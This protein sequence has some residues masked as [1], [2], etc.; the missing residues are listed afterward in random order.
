MFLNPK[1]GDHFVIILF[2]LYISIRKLGDAAIISFC[3]C[4][5]IIILDGIYLYFMYQPIYLV[6][7]KLKAYFG[8][9]RVD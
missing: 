8:A 5:R 4:F 7:K 1:K 6:V 2:S 9:A 3:A